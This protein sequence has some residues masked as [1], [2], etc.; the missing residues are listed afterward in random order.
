VLSV[1]TWYSRCDQGA[2]LSPQAVEGLLP[3]L[4]IFKHRIFS[5]L[6]SLKRFR[7][8]RLAGSDALWE[9]SSHKKG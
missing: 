3:S 2:I 4:Q 1:S 5:G 7:V 8:N 9:I 6:G